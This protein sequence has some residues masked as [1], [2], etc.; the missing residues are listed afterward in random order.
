MRKVLC[1]RNIVISFF[2]LFLATFFVVINS[3]STSP[4]LLTRGL[5]SGIFQYMGYTIL[6]GKVPYTDFFDHKG[7]FLYFFNAL[8]LL[9]N[10]SW[11]I[12]L[13]QILY[14]TMVLGVWYRGLVLVRNKAIRLLI[15]PMSLVC[16]YHCYSYGNLTEDWSLL[17]LSYPFMR[18]V[19]N[20]ECNKWNFSSSELVCIGLCVGIITMI[21]VN[22]IAPILGIVVFCAYDA[23]RR[24]EIAYLSKAVSLI[25]LGW[26]L[27]IL[28]CVI[29][30][31]TIGGLGGLQDMFYANLTFNLDYNKDHVA[32]PYDMEYI[33]FIYKVLLPIPFILVACYKRKYYLPPILIG[34]AITLLA[35]GGVHHYH[36]LIIFLPLIVF[37]MGMIKGKYRIVLF[38]CI[39]LFNVKTYYNQFSKEN[40]SLYREDTTTKLGCLLANIP[41]E[42]REHVW[43]YNGAFLLREYIG[44]N[45]IQCNRLFLPWQMDISED[46][47]KTDYNKIA[48]VR[49]KYVL[50]AE[51]VEDWMNESARYSGRA[52][53]ELF[54][55]R[56]YVV[57]S[58]VTFDDGTKVNC[59]KLID[60]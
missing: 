50:Y 21:R 27:P 17:F 14:M 7:L 20:I 54:I 19:R 8:G 38:L 11:G 15:I 47:K 42:E 26:I 34:Y 22:N 35:I 32:P 39:I 13:L 46:L 1:S 56:N 31:Y 53:D 48:Y 24:K 5:D 44:N 33:K 4:F 40:F 49:P 45:F 28:L 29:Y 16:L 52:C 41:T 36:Y 58:S 59:Y 43:S 30:M 12:L 23:I 60:N 51:Y 2:F 3:N 55:K 37:C 18:Y 57:I 9:L 6:Q 10:K 25:F